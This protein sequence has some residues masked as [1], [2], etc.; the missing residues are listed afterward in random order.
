[1][2]DAE[3]KQAMDLIKQAYAMIADALKMMGE[4]VKDDSKEGPET[5]EPKR[6]TLLG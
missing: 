3:D 6:K 5:E 2:N 4:D 1:M